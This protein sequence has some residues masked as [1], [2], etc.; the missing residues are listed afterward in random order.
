MLRIAFRLFL[1]LALHFTGAGFWVYCLISIDQHQ[2]RAYTCSWYGGSTPETD[3][4]VRYQ[5]RSSSLRVTRLP[6]V[7]ANFIPPPSEKERRSRPPRLLPDSSRISLRIPR[8]TKKQ[9]LR[10]CPILVSGPSFAA[11]FYF[12]P[13]REQRQLYSTYHSPFPLGFAF[14]VASH[15]WFVRCKRLGSITAA[16]WMRPSTLH[17]AASETN[18]IP[19]HQSTSTFWLAAISPILESALNKASRWG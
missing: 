3:R 11:L 14:P 13:R 1:R 16:A 18:P 7:S 6:T 19:S 15:S 8:L 4:I 9:F 12:R 2:F 10:C 5:Y 17:M